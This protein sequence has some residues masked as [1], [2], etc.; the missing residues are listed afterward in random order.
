VL[1]MIPA[2][3]RTKT[4]WLAMGQMWDKS[5]YDELTLRRRAQVYILMGEYSR[6]IDDCTVAIKLRPD[7]SSNFRIRAK[8]YYKLGRKALGDADT[9][10][11]DELAAA[12]AARKSRRPGNP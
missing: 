8:A 4:S 1:E 5:T 6:A 11:G 9:K 10:V 2:E 12:K 3:A 7:Q